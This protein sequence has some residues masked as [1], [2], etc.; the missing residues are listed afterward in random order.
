M[1]LP[2]LIFDIRA[3]HSGA[4]PWAQPWAPECPNVGN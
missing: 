3:Q 1:N 2:F 4:Q